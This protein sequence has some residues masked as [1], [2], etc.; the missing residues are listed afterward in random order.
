MFPSPLHSWILLS[1]PGLAELLHKKKRSIHTF[2]TKQLISLQ[3]Q[4]SRIHRALT[5]AKQLTW[6]VLFPPD[7]N[8]MRET[9]LLPHCTGEEMEDP[10]KSIT[11]PRSHILANT[12]GTCLSMKL[13]LLSRPR[14]GAA[15]ST[16]VWLLGKALGPAECCTNAVP[17]SMPPSSLI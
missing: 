6:V 9:P 15:F 5:C 3:I 10:Q 17:G 7:N 1:V 16:P 2:H 11:G 8:S 12:R 4:I 14:A 13:D